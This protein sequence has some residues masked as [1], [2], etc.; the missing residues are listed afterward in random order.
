MNDALPSVG[1]SFERRWIEQTDR[2]NRTHDNG[3]FEE[4]AEIYEMAIDEARS[5]FLD[6]GITGAYCSDV[7][8]MVIVSAAN[9]ARN[10]D[11]LND[12]RTGSEC[13]SAA[14][15]ILV[16]ALG[17]KTTHRNLRAASMQHLPRLLNELAQRSQRSGIAAE[18]AADAT[19]TIHDAA[20]SFLRTRLQ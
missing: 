7:V 2:A 6:A 10:H 9:A 14:A 13:L 1:R 12:G 3:G 4:A 20:R 5:R 16:D 19:R 11:A 8:P 18:I 17:D 15:R